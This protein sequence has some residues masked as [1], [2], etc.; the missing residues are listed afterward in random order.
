MALSQLR[1]GDIEG[2]EHR[3]LEIL[4]HVYRWINHAAPYNQQKEL[5]IAMLQAGLGC[6]S[7]WL[8]RW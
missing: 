3:S 1:T 6:L 5:Q 4:A 2:L 7:L 8:R